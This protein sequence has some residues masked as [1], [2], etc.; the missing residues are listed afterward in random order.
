ML[1][2]DDEQSH[3]L[4]ISRVVVIIASAVVIAMN[5]VAISSN[6]L[7]A[8]VDAMAMI[9]TART[10]AATTKTTLGTLVIR[11][12]NGLPAPAADYVPDQ[13]GYV[14]HVPLHRGL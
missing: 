14:L 10:I 6:S 7:S 11:N 8:K 13:L 5:T 1:L 9:I 12:P 2:I 3:H 4:V